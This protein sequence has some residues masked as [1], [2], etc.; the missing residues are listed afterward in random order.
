MTSPKD[1]NGEERAIGWG[2]FFGP[3]YRLASLTLG[4]GVVLYAFNLFIFSTL[5]TSVVEDVGGLDRIAWATTLYVVASIIASAAAGMMRIKLGARRALGLASLCFALGS[6]GIGLS[7]SMDAVLLARV[8]Q[9][10]GAGLLMASSHGLVRDL[11]PASSWPRAFAAISG[12]WGI[13]SLSGPLIGG[14]FAEMEAWRSGFLFM[15]PICG[16][17]Y[18]AVC[19]MVPASPGSDEAVQVGPALRLSLIGFSALAIGASGKGYSAAADAF[20]VGLALILAVA[21]IVVERR[22]SNPLFPV[23][24]FRPGTVVGGG[25]M[26]YFFIAFST[27]PTT[28]FGPYFLITLHE[29][30]PLVAG[31]IVT[32]Q[33]FSWTLAAILL[34]DITDKS[35][36]KII[37]LGPICTLIG[38]I[39]AAKV[40]PIGPVWLIAIAI[41]IAG[42]GIGAAWGYVGKR[43]F[44][45]AG[46]IDRDRVTTVMPTMQSL[47]M[48]FGSAVAG[49]FASRAGLGEGV[50][51]EQ[52]ADASFWVY[53][54]LA[55]G[56]MI[57]IVAAV[58]NVRG[59]SSTP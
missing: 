40:F 31:Y 55:P 14:V 53:A 30:P 58:I 47:G 28:V 51:P 7:P 25:A 42:T 41:A 23:D 35:A 57:A 18:L 21:A 34:S 3:E 12:V 44:Q 13:A 33:S 45:A 49:I 52:I 43:V 16:L 9:G 2:T 37:I 10:L 56:V 6:A 15:I 59:S 11:F 17:F 46:E 26:F 24:M 36:R 39:F 29:T 32:A 5:T 50:V 48:A 38:V 8:V 4:L 19:R 20:F 27:V 1:K 22:S 54:G